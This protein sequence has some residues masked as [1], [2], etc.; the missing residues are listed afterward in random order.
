MFREF[1]KNLPEVDSVN[2]EH[3][4]WLMTR[5]TNR[6]YERAR[7]LRKEVMSVGRTRLRGLDDG[8]PMEG[9]ESS[10]LP[11]LVIEALDLEGCRCWYLSEI[12]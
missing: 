5:S 11:R 12:Q 6:R 10:K 4:L 2:T 8:R 3:A 7:S 1:T 9:A